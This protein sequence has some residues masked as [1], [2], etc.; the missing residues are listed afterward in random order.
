MASLM[1]NQIAMFHIV[2]HKTV[3]SNWQKESSTKLY[4]VC[5]VVTSLMSMFTSS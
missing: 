5:V 4:G 2:Q 3:G 1:A